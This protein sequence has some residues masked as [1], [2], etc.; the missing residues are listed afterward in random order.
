M[1]G[2]RV[3]FVYFIPNCIFVQKFSHFLAGFIWYCIHE[4]LIDEVIQRYF[5]SIYYEVVNV[6]ISEDRNY[7]FDF[8]KRDVL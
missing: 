8:T 2:R 5:M 6:L 1:K 4:A 7:V 3:H